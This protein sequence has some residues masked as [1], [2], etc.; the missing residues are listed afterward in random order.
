M[1]FL[2]DEYLNFVKR[3]QLSLTYLAWKS[4]VPVY[5]LGPS[6]P[7]G[8]GSFFAMKNIHRYV[9]L[10]VR[11]RRV[12]NQSLS[13]LGLFAVPGGATQDHAGRVKLDVPMEQKLVAAVVVLYLPD[14]DV[15]QNVLS[16]MDQVDWVIL[17][18]NS[19]KPA[20]ELIDRFIGNPKVVSFANESNQGIAAALNTGAREALARGCEFLLTMDQ[21]SCATPEMVATLKDFLASPE[22][23][24]FAIISP[25]HLTTVAEVPGPSARPY[26][27][28]ETV[29]TSG[30]LLRLSVYQ[31]VGPFDEALFIDFVDH[32]YCL[33]LR[34]NGFKVAQSNKAVLKHNI[35]NN[36][37][38]I[39]FPVAPI[40]VSNHSSLR[41]YYITRNRFWVARKY[42][43]FKRFFWL[44]KR[45]FLAELVTIVLFEKQKAEK[46]RMI[47]RGYHDYRL[48]RLGKFATKARSEDG[49]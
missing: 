20:V 13:R 22:G 15:Y 11:F 3:G 27:E 29:W 44:D 17:V 32:E 38:K 1:Q 28:M 43:E 37:W 42:P 2:W 24:P 10:P 35:G 45:R 31:Q 23:W 9:S 19:E 30:N 40:Y 39:N 12:I 47:V 46:F 26:V 8:E 34:R 18:D 5:N 25:F 49:G 21:D 7:R 48:G 14:E 4:A 16:Y 36:L 6:D 33:R 41:R